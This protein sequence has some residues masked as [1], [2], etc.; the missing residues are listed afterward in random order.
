[1]KQKEWITYSL[2]RRDERSVE[3]RR[4]GWRDEVIFHM[5]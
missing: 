5:D 2:K 3:K 4:D 1:M